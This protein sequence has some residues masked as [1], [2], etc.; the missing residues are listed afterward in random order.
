MHLR[1]KMQQGISL[2][3]VAAMSLSNAIS[4]AAAPAVRTV[5]SDAITIE[6][7]NYSVTVNLAGNEYLGG[8]IR[9]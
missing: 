8:G 6:N 4:A 3:L 9:I 5:S 1:K 7:D 2:A